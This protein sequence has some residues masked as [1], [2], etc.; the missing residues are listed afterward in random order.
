MNLGGGGVSQHLFYFAP[1]EN[2]SDIFN[3]CIASVSQHSS[4]RLWLSW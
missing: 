4:Y 1:T 2:S 3:E